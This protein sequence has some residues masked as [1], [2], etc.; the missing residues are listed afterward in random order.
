MERSYDCLYRRSRG[1]ITAPVPL[2]VQ[3]ATMAGMYDPCLRDVVACRGA[4]FSQQVLGD[5]LASAERLSGY[6]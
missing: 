1:R 6:F 4:S 5:D 2:R 3:G